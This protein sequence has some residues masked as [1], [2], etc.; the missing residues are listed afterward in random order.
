MKTLILAAAAERYAGLTDP[1]PAHRLA[2]LREELAQD[3][4]NKEALWEFFKVSVTQ[5]CIG[6]DG[7]ISLFQNDGKECAS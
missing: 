5:V 6:K 3:Q 1:T 7:E 2:R 4:E